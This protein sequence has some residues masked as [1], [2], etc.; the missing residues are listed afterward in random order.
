MVTAGP[1]GG[2]FKITT[3]G[4]ATWNA[5]P[6]VPASTTLAIPG[7]VCFDPSSSVVS[8]RTQ[9]IYVYSPGNGVYH[10][11]NGGTS[12]SLIA[13][14]PAS[15]TPAILYAAHMR[16]AKD[17]TLYLTQKSDSNANASI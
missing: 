4:G 17:G 14:G 6:T 12:F 8:S 1:A 11:T 15:Y 10:S 9:G 13:G 16:V 5:L 7:S 2:T 3:D